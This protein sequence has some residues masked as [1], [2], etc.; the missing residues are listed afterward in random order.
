MNNGVNNNTYNNQQ[1]TNTYNNQPILTPI[2]GVQQINQGIANSPANSQTTVLQQKQQVPPQQVVNQPVTT[3]QPMPPQS[4][5]NQPKKKKKINIVQILILIIIIL[6]IYII[7]STLSH[8]AQIMNLIYNCTPI[9]SSKEE[10]KLDINSTL[11]K[12]LYGK[13]ETNIREDL[14]QPEFNDNMRLYLAYRQILETDK[15][16]SN[17]NLF[18]PQLMEPF[19]CEV[20]TKFKP[21]AFK[22]ETLEEQIKKLYGENTKIELSNIRLGNNSCIGGYQYI[23]SRGEFVQGLCSQQTA[24]SFKVTKKLVEATSSKTTIILKEE[25]KYHESEKMNLP[26]SLK[27][28]TYY[29]TFRLDMN[30]N[31]VLVSKTY[32]SKY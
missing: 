22:I 26:E 25:V 1:P 17:C 15:Y 2:T 8:Q 30:Y 16:D 12:D 27:N 5:N 20:S 9:T 21:K 11:V 19:T 24:T 14:A 29:Y 3:N 6:I 28:G 10:K 4:Q 7:Y 31:Y 18:D 23:P 13:V 32:K